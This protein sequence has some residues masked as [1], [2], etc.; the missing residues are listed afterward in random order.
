MGAG[1]S[2]WLQTFT[3]SLATRNYPDELSFI[4]VDYKSETV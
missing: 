2:E 4:L 1:K 3:T